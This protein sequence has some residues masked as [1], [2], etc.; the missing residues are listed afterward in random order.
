MP[1]KP[2]LGTRAERR[3]KLTRVLQSTHTD[4][5]CDTCISNLDNY[6][7]AQLA[8][9]DYL[10]LLPDVALHL[11]SCINCSKIYSRLYE[12]EVAEM[13]D[14]IREPQSIPLPDLA[15]LSQ[16]EAASAIDKITQLLDRS[17]RRG[18]EIISV[19]LSNM[20][21]S[22]LSTIPISTQR[23]AVA[24]SEARYS[25]VV[26][27]ISPDRFP[28]L[29]LP[30]SLTAFRDAYQPDLCLVEVKIY[31]SGLHGPELGGKKV[32]LN[33]DETIR[34]VF[35]NPGGVASFEEVP[36]S[37]LEKMEVS[38]NIQHS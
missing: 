26:L 36:I 3:S 15:F 17:L 5:D 35:T 30:F 27:E 12:L 13:E 23:E 34:Q 31:I 21:L 16:K 25:E 11:D 24:H 4:E 28:A 6:I 29:N 37:D 8:G 9:D 33:I 10:T 7:A 18:G 32:S 38:V 1:I 14:A 2:S 20:L 19:Q 22:L